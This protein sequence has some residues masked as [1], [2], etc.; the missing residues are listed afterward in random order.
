MTLLNW[1]EGAG[2]WSEA[3]IRLRLSSAKLLT[4]TGTELGNYLQ[5]AYNKFS[6]LLQDAFNQVRFLITY[7]KHVIQP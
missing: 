5:F 7:L 1:G 2:G 6:I 4:G 3:E